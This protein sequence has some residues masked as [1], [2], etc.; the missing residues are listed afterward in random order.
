MGVFV[1]ARYSCG[2]VPVGHGHARRLRAKRGH[3]ERVSGLLDGSHGQILA[4]T[5]SFV[6]DSLHNG[7]G[8]SRFAELSVYNSV[9]KLHIYDSALKFCRNSANLEQPNSEIPCTAKLEAVCLIFFIPFYG[10]ANLI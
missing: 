8:C 10:L 6:P 2:A 1:W 5:V 9:F 7:L 4:L 3:L